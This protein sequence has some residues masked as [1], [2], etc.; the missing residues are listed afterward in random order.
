MTPS[1]YCNAAQRLSPMRWWF[2][3]MTLV[4]M[5]AM[6]ATITFFGSTGTLALVL[7]G[8]LVGLPWAALCVCIWFHPERGNL[9]PTSKLMSWLPVVVQ[10]GIRWYAALFISF[11]AF[12]CG[13]ILPLFMLA[14]L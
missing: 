13:L 7:A 12:F 10:S 3:V 14:A 1:F 8:P 11:F 9:R 6:A 4:A 5:L 2:L